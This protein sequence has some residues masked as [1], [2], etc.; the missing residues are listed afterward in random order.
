MRE[1]DGP[2]CPFYLGKGLAVILALL[3]QA[4][5]LARQGHGR[6]KKLAA[7][8]DRRGVSAYMFCLTCGHTMPS[9]HFLPTGFVQ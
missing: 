8:D 2:P 9:V 7:R 6:G 4:A 1:I 5:F 3:V